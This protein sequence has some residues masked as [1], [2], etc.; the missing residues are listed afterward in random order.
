MADLS[1]LTEKN[2]T[3]ALEDDINEKNHMFWICLPDLSEGLLKI[4]DLASK[5]SRSVYFENET[6]YFT[7]LHTAFKLNHAGM[8]DLSHL[9][10]HNN[11]V[12]TDKSGKPNHP[13]HEGYVSWLPKDGFKEGYSLVP[14]DFKGRLE[15]EINELSD[16]MGK[17]ELALGG[18]SFR[19]IPDNQV[20]LMQVQIKAM[21]AYRTCLEARYNSL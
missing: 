11:F 17:L 5:F 8:K 13:D 9:S 10:D 2:Y 19:Y 6:Y 12:L 15:V 4:H 16:K 7:L 14:E 20:K 21:D 1:F 3:E 18:A